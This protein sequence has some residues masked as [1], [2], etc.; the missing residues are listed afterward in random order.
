MSYVRFDDQHE[1]GRLSEFCERLGGE[2]RIQTGEAFHI[3]QDSNDIGWGQQW[4]QRIDDSLDAVTF[5]V[6]IITP[7]F[8]KSPAC[9][10]EL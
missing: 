9:R 2:V 3:F 5:L 7:G 10:A 1:N 8:F 4:Q 6:P